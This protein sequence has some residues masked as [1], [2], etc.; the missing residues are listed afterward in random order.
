MQ[1]N[2]KVCVTKKKI[3]PSGTIGLSP[4]DKMKNSFDI[5]IRVQATKIGQ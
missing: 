5:I 3:K 1:I 2:K 4:N